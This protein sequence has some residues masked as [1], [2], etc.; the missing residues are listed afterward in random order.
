MQRH[1]SFTNTQMKFLKRKNIGDA[2][3]FKFANDYDLTG[4]QANIGLINLLDYI[5]KKGDFTEK[6][7]FVSKLICLEVFKNMDTQE[8]I[9]IHHYIQHTS[10][11]GTCN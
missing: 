6:P 1:F 5:D 4:K 2:Q 11:P 10:D 8:K 3:L 9:T 7:L